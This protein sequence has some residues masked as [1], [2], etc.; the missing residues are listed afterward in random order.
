M[1]RPT[2]VQTMVVQLECESLPASTG[3][4]AS[5]GSIYCLN[6]KL[7]WLGSTVARTPYN[8][9]HMMSCPCPRTEAD[10]GVRVHRA[11]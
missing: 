6:N 11:L 8:M 3:I 10:K 9:V 4:D 5:Q 7:K 2:V 1:P